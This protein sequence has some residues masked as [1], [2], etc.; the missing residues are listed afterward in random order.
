[1]KNIAKKY[2]DKKI[3]IIK[4]I[5]FEN[6][7]STINI[8]KKAWNKKKQIF[9][10]GNG[11]SALTAQHFV[12]DWNKSIFMK[13]K[14]PFLGKCLVDNIGLISAYSNDIS[15]EQIFTAQLKNLAMPGDVLIAISGSGNSRNVINAVKYS[16][17]NKIHTISLVG[18]NGGELIKIAKNSIHIESSDMQIIEDFHLS[19]GH[20]IMQKLCR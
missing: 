8:I 7:E 18:F 6:I 17:I 9:T 20:I 4:K 10:I 1:M 14:K 3:E 13:H 16:N 11:G 19:I 2:F 5:N 12:T 15:Y